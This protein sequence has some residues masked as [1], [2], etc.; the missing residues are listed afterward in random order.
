[1]AVSDSRPA[2]WVA[3]A[4]PGDESY[5]HEMPNLDKAEQH[6]YGC[7][8][9]NEYL[10]PHGPGQKVTAYHSVGHETC[11]DG[12]ENVGDHGSENDQAGRGAG[13]V[14]GEVV[15]EP[16]SGDDDGPGAGVGAEGRKPEMPKV[17]VGEGRKES[18]GG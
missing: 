10:E 3:M 18:V 16:A 17:S 6:Q 8:N 15:G 14:L 2:T 5:H 7:T 12:D 11:E 4:L 1:M 13:I 9:V